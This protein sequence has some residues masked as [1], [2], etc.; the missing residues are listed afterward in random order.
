MSHTEEIMARARAAGQGH[1]F[2]WWDELSPVQQSQLVEQV[3][4]IDFDEIE[5]LI[6]LAKGMRNSECGIRNRKTA[7]PPSVSCSAGADAFR[8]PNSEF[9]ILPVDYLPCPA[10]PSEKEA[11]NRAAKLG[12]AALREGRV[13]A[14]VVAGGQGTRLGFDHPK[15]MFPIGP[16]TRKSL[17]EVHAHKLI[18]LSRRYGA[19]IPLYVMTSGATHAGTVRYFEARDYLGLGRENVRFFQQRMLPA[20]DAEY[21]VILAEKHRVFMSPNGHGG[22]LSALEEEGMLDDMESRG[23]E[24]ISYFQ[25][26]NPL[27]HPADPVFIGYHLEGGAE[28]SSKA[29]MKRDAEEKLGVFG[30]VEGELRVMEYSD[31]S[32]DE[33]YA[34]DA[35]GNLRYGLGSPAMHL[36]AVRFARQLNEAG[37]RLPC[38]IARKKVPYINDHGRGVEPAVKNGIKFEMFIFDALRYTTKSV[39]MQIRREEEF[40]PVKNAEGEDSAATA[41]RDMSNQFGR[42]LEAAGVDVP[43]DEQG[44]VSVRLEIDPRFA[45]DGEELKGKIDARLRIEGDLHL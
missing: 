32:R 30:R 12:E 19:A 27:V 1:L 38:H 20:L 26:D 13:G 45:L 3:G 9:R 21:R 2:R 44:N 36:I 28:M 33:M 18:A 24:V 29:L 43:R 8:I 42:W 31:L 11:R 10:T 40:S 35:E 15:G 41:R 5:R 6:E 23:I 34:R 4:T 39:I 17:F 16:V 22:A 7:V 37:R 14:V 25:V